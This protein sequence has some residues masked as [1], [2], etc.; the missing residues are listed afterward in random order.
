MRRLSIGGK[1][2]EVRDDYSLN[3]IDS[4]ISGYYLLAEAYHNYHISGFS[5]WK[6]AFQI[7][8]VGQDELIR[9][10]TDNIDD[11]ELLKAFNSMKERLQ[12]LK[13]VDGQI[14]EWLAGFVGLPSLQE[15]K[16]KAKLGKRL[17]NIIARGPDEHPQGPVW[18]IRPGYQELVE[19]SGKILA[20]MSEIQQQA[21][22][23]LQQ[24]RRSSTG[25]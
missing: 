5:D 8:D 12:E 1:V 25:A 24:L 2:V 14:T 6:N 10:I 15:K 16:D 18:A 17:K 7:P 19:R 21:Q 13:N 9:T 23:R 4:L 22:L 20:D 3:S 11:D